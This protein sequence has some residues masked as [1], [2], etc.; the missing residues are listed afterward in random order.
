MPATTMT[1]AVMVGVTVMMMPLQRLVAT[2]SGWP[3][4]SAVGRPA[5]KEQ[6]E[7]RATLP[8]VTGKPGGSGTGDRS[9]NRGMYTAYVDLYIRYTFCHTAGV[10]TFTED[11]R[12]CGEDDVFFC[13]VRPC[14]IAVHA[15]SSGHSEICSTNAAIPPDRRFPARFSA[16]RLN[17]RPEKIAR[18]GWMTIRST[19][20]GRLAPPSC[21]CRSSRRWR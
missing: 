1:M 7:H 21:R 13:P 17:A 12:S 3:P 5:S 19:P 6:E 4:R 15:G 18:A 8:P 11:V 10:T 16:F 14:L 9:R 20:R 2:V